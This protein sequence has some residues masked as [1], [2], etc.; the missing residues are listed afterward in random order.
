MALQTIMNCYPPCEDLA[1]GSHRRP[2]LAALRGNNVW[3][4]QG[5]N[6]MAIENLGTVGIWARHSSVSPQVAS[7]LERLGYS[8]IWLGASPPLSWTL[9]IRC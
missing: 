7:E 1:T 4:H 5:F 8:A 3:R 6:G 2:A 9:S